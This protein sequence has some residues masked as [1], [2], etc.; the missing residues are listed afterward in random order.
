MLHIREHRSRENCFMCTGSQLSTTNGLSETQK[1]E[2]RKLTARP[3]REVFI[4]SICSAREASYF[5]QTLAP[6]YPHNTQL[7][8]KWKIFTELASSALRN[9]IIKFSAPRALTG[10]RSKHLL[11]LWQTII[12]QLSK[13]TNNS[14]HRRFQATSL[15]L[16]ENRLYLGKLKYYEV[17]FRIYIFKRRKIFKYNDRADQLLIYVGSD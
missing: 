1:A 6:N 7:K 11:S 9:I 15:S 3:K 17:L 2:A 13:E 14:F 4:F 16:V 5:Y 12:S 10:R 8:S